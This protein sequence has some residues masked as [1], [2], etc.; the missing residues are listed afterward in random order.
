MGWTGYLELLWSEFRSRYIL[1]FLSVFQSCVFDKNFT[2]GFSVEKM[3][4]VSNI[5]FRKVKTEIVNA[6]IVSRS[7]STLRNSKF[8]H[9]ATGILTKVSKVS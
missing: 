7:T 2:M 4:K 6:Q 8:N 3:T 1:K 5:L 9:E